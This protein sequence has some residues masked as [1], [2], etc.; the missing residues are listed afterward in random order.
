MTCHGGVKPAEG[1][2]FTTSSSGYSGLV[3]KASTQC[4]TTKLRVKPNDLAG[5]YLWNKL[6][7][8][9]MCSGS[10]MPKA[11]VSLTQAQLDTVRAW[12]L[13]GAQQ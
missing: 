8:S 6:L 10:Q 13:T 9:G 4:T 1:L 2:D 3:N 11:G 7:G 12:I 5:S